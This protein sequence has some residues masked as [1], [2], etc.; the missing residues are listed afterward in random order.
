MEVTIRQAQSSDIEAMLLLLEELFSIEKDFDFDSAKS[1]KGLEMIITGTKDKAIFVADC[2]RMVVGMCSVQSVISTAE[3]Q[4]SG[5]VEDLVVNK[6]FRRKGVAS[7]LLGR[8]EKWA[9]DNGIKR[10]QL[11]ADINNKS[12]LDFYHGKRWSKTQLI[13][14]RKYTEDI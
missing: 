1:R 9:M 14:L 13:C 6:R 5:L 4:N 12:A 11:L 8:I 7:L 3:G 2:C 10:L